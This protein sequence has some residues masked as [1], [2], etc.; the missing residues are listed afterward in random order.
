MSVSMFTMLP[1][2]PQP[3]TCTFGPCTQCT[4]SVMC[5]VTVSALVK[6]HHIL[7]PTICVPIAHLNICS[8][9]GSYWNLYT[10]THLNTC[11]KLM[12]A[13]LTYHQEP[14]HLKAWGKVSV[15]IWTIHWHGLLPG[16]S[17]N[18]SI[19]MKTWEVFECGNCYG[20]S[21][22]SHFML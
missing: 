7:Y 19:E 20:N 1:Q 17:G 4:Y 16:S 14:E 3:T 2:H 6:L 22:N 5:T 8:L 15:F 18:A 9:V 10:W 21:S 11:N 13:F 12:L